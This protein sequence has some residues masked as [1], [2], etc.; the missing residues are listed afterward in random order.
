ML[1][2]LLCGCQVPARGLAPLPA[3]PVAP[4]PQAAVPP[5]A[6]TPEQADT[7]SPTV[8]TL[9]QATLT[10][11]ATVTDTPPA[12]GWQPITEDVQDLAERFA[13]RIVSPDADKANPPMSL[14]YAPYRQG[15]VVALRYLVLYQDEDLKSGWEDK[16]YD[17]FRQH[18]YGSVVDI[19]PIEVYVRESDSELAGVAFKTGQNQAFYKVFVKEN[20]WLTIPAANL[21]ASDRDGDHP[22]IG[23]STWN[24]LH[25]LP[26]VLANRPYPPTLQ[27]PAVPVTRLDAEAQRRWRFDRR[28]LV[29]GPMGDVRQLVT[30][31][32]VVR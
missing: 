6:T 18:H 5:A 14:L 26:S 9:I 22:R 28:H 11:A 3:L 21:K 19:E 32:S 12:T 2:A 7:A 31:R 10:T 15:D 20:D 30:D 27:S 4:L 23:V 13:P 17:L 24:H 8:N 25:D 29:G 16:L 1:L